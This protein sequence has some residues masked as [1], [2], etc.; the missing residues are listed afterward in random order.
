VT[1][2]AHTWDYRDRPAEVDQY[3]V[4]G[5]ASTLTA[6]AHYAFNAADQRI[7]KALD[8]N[9]DGSVETWEAYTYDGANMVW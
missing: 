2:T 9:A 7:T 1:H 4:S 8:S 3:A 5:T 6:T